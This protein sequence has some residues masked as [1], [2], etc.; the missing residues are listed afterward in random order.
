M[1]TVKVIKN[2]KGYTVKVVPDSKKLEYISEN[3][4]EMDM[5]A[6]QAV[7]NAVEK[8]KICKKPVAKYDLKTKRA[9]IEYPDGEKKYV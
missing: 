8:A 6:T 7:K 5:R 1:A 4:V 9:Y 2:R 3:D